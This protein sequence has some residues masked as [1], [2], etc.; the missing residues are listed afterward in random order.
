MDAEYNSVASNIVNT[1]Q[2]GFM[3]EDGDALSALFVFDNQAIN[4]IGRELSDVDNFETYTV[5]IG[6]PTF[7]QF[8]GTYLEYVRDS[9]WLDAEE[10][11]KQLCR[12]AE[13][14]TALLSASQGPWLIPVMRPLTL[15]L[16]QSAQRT[17]ESTH[18]PAAFAQAASVLLRL[19][20]DLLADNGGPLEQSKRV[21]CLFVA[22]LLLRISLRTSAAPGAYASKALEVKNLWGS[23]VFS[24]RD[25]VSYS[26]WLGRYYL[27]CYYVDSARSQLEYAF[28]GCPAWH[29]RNKRAVLRYLFVANMIRGQ[30]AHPALLEKYQMEPVYAELAWHFRKG[31]LAMF[32]QVLIANMEFFR[33]QGNF[34]IL[35]E[36]TEILIYRN[37]LMRSSALN[38]R[39]ELGRAMPYRDVLAAFQLSSQNYS[40]DY[41]EMESILA[42]LVAQKFVLGFLFHHQKLVNLA[43]K[44]PFPP[45]SSVGVAINSQ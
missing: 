21:G 30:L 35:M 43:K 13:L 6:D 10:Q 32:Q 40:M 26:Y 44:S 16:C 20:I 17:F 15:A 25:R 42:S 31:N 4:T 45:I 41:A 33:S 28:N 5:C 9:S 8:T 14:F 36:R 27:V 7:A 34:L 18:D 23:S 3:F 29:M 38:S 24:Q 19:L 2:D 12:V 1:A 37:V 11:H 22:G 39:S